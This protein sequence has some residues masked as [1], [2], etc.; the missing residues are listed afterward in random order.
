MTEINNEMLFK[1][2]VFI[3]LIMFIIRL[4]VM[5]RPRK[6]IYKCAAK[7]DF[8]K[9]DHDY[10]FQIER[11]IDGYY[12]CYIERAP[13]LFGKHFY[14]YTDTYVEEKDTNRRFILYNRKIRSV[15]RA[16]EICIDW[17]NSN[18]THIDFCRADS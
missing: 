10:V 2:S 7:T 6:V 3:I 5:C 18:Q 15:E 12:R 13:L 11:M 1:A 4:P 14:R 8:K 17:S 9:L 16:R